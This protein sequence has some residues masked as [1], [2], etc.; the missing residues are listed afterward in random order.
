VEI[1]YLQLLKGTPKSHS[2]KFV[3]R[4]LSIEEI[5]R[6]E[7]LYNNGNPFPKSYR[8]FLFLAGEFSWFFAGGDELEK[9]MRQCYSDLKYSQ[10]V[11]NR[12]FVVYDTNS[13]EGYNIIYLDEGEEDPNGHYILAMP[14]NEMPGG[15]KMFGGP[16][17]R[18]SELV[19]KSIKYRKHRFDEFGY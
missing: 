8:E 11:V 14:Q 16:F 3:N 12:P 5:E 7:I 18:F 2:E 4:G 17:E 13:G 9:L 10:I 1:E 15:E 6:L 19:E